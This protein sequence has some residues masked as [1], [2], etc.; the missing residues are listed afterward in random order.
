MEQTNSKL[1]TQNSKLVLVIGYGNDLRG[2]DAIGVYVAEQVAARGLAGVRA[3]GIPQLTP[4]L[5]EEL[6][7]AD[8][9]IFVDA[10]PLVW[11]QESALGAQAVEWQA[12]A[13]RAGNSAHGHS[14]DPRALLA[15]A[16]ALYG[17]APPA[18]LLAVPAVNF[19]LGAP[20]SPV[21]R[22]GLE[23]A[24]RSLIELL[25]PIPIERGTST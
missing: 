2:D 6:A 21:G 16:Q 23:A 17:H 19:E 20:L 18:W 22:Q 11:K 12:L 8:M 3:I 15:L 1:K 9:A 25:D 5:A 24:T 7:R 13:P 4:E 10:R 14:S